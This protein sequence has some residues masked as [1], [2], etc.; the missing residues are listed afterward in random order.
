M[1]YFRQVNANLNSTGLASKQH[2]LFQELCAILGETSG[3]LTEFMEGYPKHT[4]IEAYNIDEFYKSGYES[5]D[6]QEA[7]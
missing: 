2:S 5:Y 7:V 1:D 4:S 3:L 6:E